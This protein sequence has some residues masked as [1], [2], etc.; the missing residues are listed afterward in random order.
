MSSQLATVFLR[1]KKPGYMSSSV[2]PN[3]KLH[4][5]VNISTVWNIFVELPRFPGRILN[6]VPIT[7]SIWIATSLQPINIES[8]HHQHHSTHF[9]EIGTLAQVVNDRLHSNSG[10]LHPAEN[11]EARTTIINTHSLPDNE[12]IYVLY[13]YPGDVCLD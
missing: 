2:I 4:A 5:P 9:S 12:R 13:I 3:L 10:L 8:G 7:N 11:C 6:K 1:I